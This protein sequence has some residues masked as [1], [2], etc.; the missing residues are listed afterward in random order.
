MRSTYKGIYHQGESHAADFQIV[1]LK[2]FVSCLK[3]RER[4]ASPKC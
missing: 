4:A 1:R 2:E 3:L